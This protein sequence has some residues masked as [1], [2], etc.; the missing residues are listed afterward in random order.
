MKVFRNFYAS[1]KFERNLNA[2]FIVLI[3]KIPRI[4]NPKY[5]HPISLVSDIYKII[6][7][8]LANKLKM[9]L[10]KIISMLHNAFVQGR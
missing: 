9:M 3:R 6:V 1:G 7:K 5:F 4:V 8:I 2:T 10:E